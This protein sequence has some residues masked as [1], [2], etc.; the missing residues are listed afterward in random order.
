VLALKQRAVALVLVTGLAAGLIG[1]VPAENLPSNC[2]DPA[3]SFT[4]TL[5]ADGMSP[6][7]FD[8]CRDQQLTF[9]I[10]SE[11]AGE[12][13]FHGYDGIVDEQE[14]TVGQ[15]LK[16]EFKAT[17]PGQFPIELHPA[18]GSE[19]RAVATLTVHER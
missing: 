8:V 19:E 2:G 6:N 5:K 18:D 1:C 15:T 14:V 12:L 3:V 16:V 4:A 13:H 9:D 17:R 11:A 10:T 7:A